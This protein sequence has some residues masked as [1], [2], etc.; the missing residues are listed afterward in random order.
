MLA[1][2]ISSIAMAFVGGDECGV[3]RHT[4]TESTP[5]DTSLRLTID[6]GWRVFRV[7]SDAQPRGLTAGFG[8]EGEHG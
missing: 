4:D 7:L 1:P 5:T 6:G 8:G 3:D 2:E